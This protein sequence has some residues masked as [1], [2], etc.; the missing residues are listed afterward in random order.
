MGRVA[1]EVAAD[2]TMIQPTRNREPVGAELR[3][4]MGLLAL[5][6]EQFGLVSVTDGCAPEGR[7][8]GRRATGPLHRR[9]AARAGR[10]WCRWTC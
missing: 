4:G 3:E 8:S 2:E 9:P 6:R 10:S 5:L 7:S 1:Q